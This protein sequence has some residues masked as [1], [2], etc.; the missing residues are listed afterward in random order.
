[1]S[2]LAIVRPETIY[3][4]YSDRPNPVGGSI[5]KSA[6]SDMEV[7]NDEELLLSVKKLVPVQPNAVVSTIVVLSDE[8]CFIQPFEEGK[9]EEAE[10]KLISTT[11]FAHVVTACITAHDQSYL[12]ATNQD[13]YESISRS[14]ASQQHPV[15]LVV[16]WSALVQLGLTKGEVD[17]ATVKRVF[18]GSSALRLSAFPFVTEKQGAVVAVTAP[19]GKAPKK[20]PWG[21]IVFGGAALLYALTMYWFFIRG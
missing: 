5:A 6:V 17:N 9:R 8:L 3:V 7:V 18:D 19:K 4:Y 1:M 21:W 11:P 10:A 14:L 2:A 13:Y 16:P 15:A 20:T 12:I